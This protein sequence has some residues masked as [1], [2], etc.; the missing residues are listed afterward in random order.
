M[1]WRSFFLA[2]GITTIIFGLECLIVKKAV[3][4]DQF[5]SVETRTSDDL[6]VDALQP[7]VVK[8]VVHTP[9]WAPWSLLSVGA[10]VILYAVSMRGNQGG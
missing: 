6:F 7:Q 5:A 4:A 9:E 10:V 1:M 8:R 3:L 2:I